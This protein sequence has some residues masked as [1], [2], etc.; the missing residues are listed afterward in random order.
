MKLVGY[1][2]LFLPRW[3]VSRGSIRYVVSFFQGT[4]H[5]KLCQVSPVKLNIAHSKRKTRDAEADVRPELC[6]LHRLARPSRKYMSGSPST[7]DSREMSWQQLAVFSSGSPIA[8][9]SAATRPTS[10]SCSATG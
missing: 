10:L 4:E 5:N 3:H 1:G 2:L 6:W 7:H 9:G 8:F